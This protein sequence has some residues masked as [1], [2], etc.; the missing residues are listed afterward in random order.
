MLFAVASTPD[1]K[2][3]QTRG[4]LYALLGVAMLCSATVLVAER[5][6]AP[7]FSWVVENGMVCCTVARPPFEASERT[8]DPAR[9]QK[10]VAAEHDSIPGGMVVRFE[11]SGLNYH[12]PAQNSRS[13][14]SFDRYVEELDA[15][16][17]RA[18]SG[19]ADARLRW[20][21]R[22]LRVMVVSAAIAVV[23]WVWLFAVLRRRRP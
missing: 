9:I 10:V 13:I 1:S 22:G 2:A 14:S 16:M 20:P 17:A 5:V 11:M 8:Y 6:Q 15:F 3:V 7:S 21:S 19:D 18:R 12:L 23:S 4:Q